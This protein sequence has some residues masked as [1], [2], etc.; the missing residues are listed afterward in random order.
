MCV[1]LQPGDGGR[2]T[3]QWDTA[4]CCG[5][6]RGTARSQASSCVEPC[7]LSLT[8]F[9]TSI[10][11]WYVVILC[12]LNSLMSCK[13]AGLGLG[14]TGG[15]CFACGQPTLLAQQ[16]PVLSSSPPHHPPHLPGSGSSQLTV[17]CFPASWA[18]VVKLWLL[19]PRVQRERFVKPAV[20]PA[21]PGSISAVT[22][23]TGTPTL[24]VTSPHSPMDVSRS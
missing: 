7:T 19:Q 24:A 17:S 9:I 20:P 18:H 12:L 3:L 13:I 6:T 2:A 1:Y 8:Q 14:S 4:E 16:T 15:R 23:G 21:N 10:E 5:V 11:S 22:P